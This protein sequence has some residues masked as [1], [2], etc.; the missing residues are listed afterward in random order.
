MTCSMRLVTEPRRRAADSMK[1]AWLLDGGHAPRAQVAADDTDDHPDVARKHQGVGRHT[2]CIEAGDGRSTGGIH[3]LDPALRERSSSISPNAMRRPFRRPGQ[4]GDH[5]GRPKRHL[6]P[7][8]KVV[9]SRSVRRRSTPPDASMPSRGLNASAKTDRSLSTN[10][11]S[12]PVAVSQMRRSASALALA[13]IVV[14]GRTADELQFC[15]MTRSCRRNAPDAVSNTRIS[16]NSP[17]VTSIVPSAENAAARVGAA[18]GRR[19]STSPVRQ[20]R[21]SCGPATVPGDAPDLA[22]VGRR[23]DGEHARGVW[24]EH[25]RWSRVAAVPHGYLAVRQSRGN[26]RRPVDR[27]QTRDAGWQSHGCRCGRTPVAPGVREQSLLATA[28]TVAMPNQMNADV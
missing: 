27:G 10:L 2:A 7:A 14:P 24:F 8:L 9:E 23:A 17:P 26:R 1:T 3:D 16:P 11:I 28:R 18:P 13:T 15:A 12:R 22:T 4:R 20:A 5:L 6:S 19:A 21:S 25:D